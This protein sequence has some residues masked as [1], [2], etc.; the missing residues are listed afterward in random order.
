MATTCFTFSRVD[1]LAQNN[2]GGDCGPLCVKFIE[3]H[4]H[5]LHDALNS[6]TDAAVD[7][8]RAHY[9]ID[10]YEDSVEPI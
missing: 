9:T 3:L 2:R 8:L 10:L 6:L 1:G 4:S 5:S 7:N